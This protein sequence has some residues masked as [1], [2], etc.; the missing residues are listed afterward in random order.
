MSWI[1]P[2]SAFLSLSL[3]MTTKTVSRGKPGKNL[4]GCLHYTTDK[5]TSIMSGNVPSNCMLHTLG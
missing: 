1:E 4:E 5:S 3:M 2:E